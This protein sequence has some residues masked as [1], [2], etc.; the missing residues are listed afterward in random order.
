[1]EFYLFG[2]II[3]F[4]GSV[5]IF[6]YFLEIFKDKKII[7]SLQIKME[8]L[9]I[10]DDC[11]HVRLKNSIYKSCAE[12]GCFLHPKTKFSNQECPLGKWLN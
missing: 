8:R 9:K 10:C 7:S 5:L 3:L 4:L 1:M 6:L 12:C 2:I 11:E